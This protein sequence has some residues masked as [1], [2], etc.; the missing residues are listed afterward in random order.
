MTREYETGYRKPPKTTRFK[1]GRSGNPKG[2]P[3]RSRNFL[4]L[5]KEELAQKVIISEQGAKRS[6]SKMEA[7]I[8]RMV[9]GALQGDQKS[10]VTL[11]E[12]LKR[13]N[14]LRE[15][16]EIGE[17]IMPEEYEKILEDY[18]RR[19]LEAQKPDKRRGR[20]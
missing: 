14:Q 3:K 19:R 11:I 18:V 16:E 10:M 9:A 4:T 6:I 2:R 7:M 1:K 8:K 15:I 13:A 12:I 17:E 5:L 20:R